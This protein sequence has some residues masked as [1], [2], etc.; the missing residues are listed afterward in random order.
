MLI[1]I[2]GWYGEKNAGDEAFKFVFNEMFSYHDIVY[3]KKIIKEA[4]RVILGGGGVM[5]GDYLDELGSRAVYAIGVDI[6][7]SGATYD[8]LRQINFKSIVTRSEL[9]AGVANSQ[10]WHAVSYAPD[11]A[12]AL[13]YPKH[14]C[15]KDRVGIILNHELNEDAL[16][17]VSLFIKH[18]FAIGKRP[19][20][21]TMYDGL[22]KP[23]FNVCKKIQSNFL[24][25]IPIFRNHKPIDVIQHIA[26]CEFVMSMRFHGSIFAAGCGVPF[27]S[28][29]NRGKHSLFCEQEGIPLSFINL[30]DFDADL[31]KERYNLN[32]NLI[33]SF[34]DNYNLLHRD[35]LPAFKQ[36]VISGI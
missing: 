36:R 5:C 2:I 4:D 30:K 6:H 16:A 27:L 35:I 33:P 15:A 29:A 21:I 18:L 31:L 32:R 14:E 10:G 24:E 17:E 25:Y 34:E 26:S 19:F 11:I 7:L 23:D 12:F 8:Q 3:S 28:L 9:Y 20:F 22:E 13:D 1:N